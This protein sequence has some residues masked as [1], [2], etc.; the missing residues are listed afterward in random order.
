MLL[1]T[2]HVVSCLAR[3]VIKRVIVSPQK[4]IDQVGKVAKDSTGVHAPMLLVMTMA[5]GW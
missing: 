4:T 1:N 3:G 5:S 2:L